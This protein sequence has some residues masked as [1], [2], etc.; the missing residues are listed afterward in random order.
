MLKKAQ[1]HNCRAIGGVSWASS[2]WWGRSPPL[3]TT[4]VRPRTPQGG[5]LWQ[6]EVNGRWNWLSPFLGHWLVTP[7]RDGASSWLCRWLSWRL[8]T[9]GHGGHHLPVA[10]IWGWWEGPEFFVQPESLVQ[11]LG[12]EQSVQEERTNWGGSRYPLSSI[13]VPHGLEYEAIIPTYCPDTREHNKERG[14][15]SESAHRFCLVSHGYHMCCVLCFGR[16]LLFLCSQTL[17]RSVELDGE[18]P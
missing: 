3:R 14:P 7:V 15:A 1:V 2:W 8:R 13:H 4:S 12:R 9:W 11:V 16:G 5:A 10:L 6:W 18:F 17:W